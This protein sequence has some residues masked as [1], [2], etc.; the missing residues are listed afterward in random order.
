MYLP[1]FPSIMREFTV[2][3]SI[4]QLTLS[5][6][7][8]G[9]G[10]AQLIFGPLSDRIGRR[11]VIFGGGV[12]FILSCIGC[13]YVKDINLFIVL[14]FFQGAAVCSVAV[15]GYAAIHESFAD[16]QAVKLIAFMSMIAV[17]APMVGP[18]AGGYVVTHYSWQTI[19]AIIMWI[20]IVAMIGLYFVMPE[21]L[22]DKNRNS[23]NI[24]NLI[25]E[26]KE[27]LTNKE[28]IRYCIIF[29]F[30]VAGLLAWIATGP[31]YLMIQ[32]RFSPEEFGFA[33]IPV[34]GG[35][36]IGSLIVRLQVE[37]VAMRSLLKL[38]LSICFVGAFIILATVVVDE[39]F[40]A[41]VIVGMSIYGIGFGT[42][43]A[44]VARLAFN[45][46]TGGKGVVNA[47]YSS[48]MLMISSGVTLI[49]SAIGSESLSVFAVIVNLM[50]II[51]FIGFYWN[52]RASS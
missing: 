26:Y 10:L 48:S 19:F 28:F 22:V 3:E 1:A 39:S 9:N 34:F 2:D 17:W 46:S 24:R 42:A 38:G 52:K 25:A 23:M 27:V 40:A 21:T 41:A 51:G 18:L 50:V 14:R 30:T 36:M 43:A 6:W 49:I 12:V 32:N 7:L 5:S 8:L 33:Q 13:I 29:G 16:N 37:R 15:A 4:V 35:F 44:P 31:V 11:P 20:T 45:S 47:V